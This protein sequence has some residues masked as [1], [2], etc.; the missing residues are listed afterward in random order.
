MPGAHAVAGGPKLSSSTT[1]AR[2]PGRESTRARSAAR[3]SV[4]A[5][6]SGKWA[7]GW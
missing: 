4:T 7:R 6:P 1:G 3:R 2:A 5:W